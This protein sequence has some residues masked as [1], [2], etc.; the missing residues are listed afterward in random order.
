MADVITRFKLE[1]TQYDSKLRDAAKSLS[2]YAKQ[3][4]LAG[5]EFGKLTEKNVEAAK[6]LGSIAPSANN[7]KDKVKELVTAYNDVSKAY[8]K[9]TV[10]QKNTDYGKALAGSLVQLKGKVTDAKQELYGLGD[11]MEKGKSAGVDFNSVL[12]SLGQRFGI[13]QGRQDA[14]NAR[15]PLLHRGRRALA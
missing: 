5:N 9:L 8:N 2:D 10:E 1:T 11:A 6:A 13:G 14:R 12:A 4:T 7:A 15:K 3:A